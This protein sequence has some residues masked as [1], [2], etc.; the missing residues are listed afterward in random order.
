MKI[1]TLLFFY[2]I[3]IISFSQPINR[4]FEGANGRIKLL[5]VASLDRLA[6][7][8][9]A[10]WYLKNYSEYEVA[11][12]NVD[13][14]KADSITVFMGTWC[15]DSK[16]EVPRF[17]KILD[18]A[19]YDLSKLKIVCLN[20]G[21]QNYKQAPEREERGLNIHRVP[22]IIF[23]NDDG[24]EI[25]RIVEEPVVSL[26]EDIIEVLNGKEYHTAYPVAQ[27]MIEYFEKFSL[28]ELKK[29]KPKLVNEFDSIENIYELGTY[30]YVLWSSFQ[31]PKAQFVFELNA[32]LFPEEARVHQR[33]AQFMNSL[34]KE[35][36]A[37]VSIKKG[38]KA[39]PEN[40]GLI[41]MRKM[42]SAK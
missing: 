20:T 4:S 33:L 23:H 13:L 18:A 15:G 36:E 24:G 10:E 5:G 39:D 26:E 40:E 38:L 16:R 42:I 7:E 41:E 28:K 27:R 8:P 6:E 11:E 21:F 3:S 34:G 31:L 29:M 14:S 35:K 25:G 37:L 22:T 1:L 2:S 30:G 19:K 9:F 32:E 12:V 17:V